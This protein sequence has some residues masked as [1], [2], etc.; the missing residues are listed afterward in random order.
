MKRLVAVFSV[1]TSSLRRAYLTDTARDESVPYIDDG[2]M[3]VS[4]SR[5]DERTEML[6]LGEKDF[7]PLLSK[8]EILTAKTLCRKR[9]RLRSCTV[10]FSAFRL[11]KVI[12][13]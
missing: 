3:R 12:A 7:L 13:Y 10:A 2:E 9:S 5:I 11:A 6:V 8:R 1:A 4:D